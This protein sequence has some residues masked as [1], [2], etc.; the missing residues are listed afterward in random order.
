MAKKKKKAGKK[1]PV[2]DRVTLALT[3]IVVGVLAIFTGYM[4]GQY[5]I[6]WVASPLTETTPRLET[7]TVP[8]QTAPDPVT[9]PV[10]RGDSALSERPSSGTSQGATAPQ[11][12]V[13]VS[14][15]QPVEEPAAQQRQTIVRVQVGRF[16]TREQAAT[17][18]EQLKEGTPP[19]EDAWV[20]FDE[21]SGEYRV[22]V[23]AFSNAARASE[24][25]QQLRSRNLDAFIVP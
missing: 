4:V 3:L 21:K 8:I 12:P 20:L 1:N 17:L 11:R 15:V 19:I 6:T 10:S 14:P 2:W 24:L 16:T 23:G 7:A 25:A 5:A 22:Q 9:M 13:P 18:A